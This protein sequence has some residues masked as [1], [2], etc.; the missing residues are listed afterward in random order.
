MSFSLFGKT[1]DNEEYF[2]AYYETAKKLGKACFFGE[3]GDMLDM[4][5]APDVIVEVIRLE[6]AVAKDVATLLNDWISKRKTSDDD[7]K[8]GARRGVFLTGVLGALISASRSRMPASVLGGNTSKEK[9]M[10]SFRMSAT[11][12]VFLPVIC[13]LRFQRVYLKAMYTHAQL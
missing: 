5:T 2:R 6:H 13:L 11:L 10:R 9:V 1:I 12:I 7:V 8:P 4:E 3:F